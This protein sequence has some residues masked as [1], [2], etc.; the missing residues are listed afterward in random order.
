MIVA[1]A[2]HVDHG[3]SALVRQL[4]GIETDTLQTEKERGLTINLGYAYHR[5]RTE[6]E[7]ATAPITLGFIDVPGHTDFIHNMLAGVSSVH[8]ALLVVASDDGIMPQTR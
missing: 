2:G 4:T 3:K 7:P 1:T 8:S 5:F 6:C